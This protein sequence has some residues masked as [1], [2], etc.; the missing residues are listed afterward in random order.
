MN[1]KKPSSKKEFSKE[2]KQEIKPKHMVLNTNKSKHIT[3]DQNTYYI[4]KNFL[5]KN[6]ANSPQNIEEVLEVKPFKSLNDI[7]IE[8]DD[9]YT[10]LVMATDDFKNWTLLTVVS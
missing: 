10:V 1:L 2:E 4:P 7:V 6:E 3:K 9:E 5:F 8:N